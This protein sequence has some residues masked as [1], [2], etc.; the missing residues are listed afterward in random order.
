MDKKVASIPAKSKP[1]DSTAISDFY[2][3]SPLDVKIPDDWKRD[4]ADWF[5]KP[6]RGEHYVSK[7]GTAVVFLGSVVKPDPRRVIIVE[8][9]AKEKMPKVGR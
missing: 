1:L 5:R 7:L 9:S 2:A 3:T 8:K 6:L 4:G